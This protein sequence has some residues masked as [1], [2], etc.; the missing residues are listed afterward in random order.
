VA[1][2]AVDGL[3]FVD[4]DAAGGTTITVVLPPPVAPLAPVAPAAPVAPV[5]PV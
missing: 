5:S 1:G 4:P 3:H 2:D